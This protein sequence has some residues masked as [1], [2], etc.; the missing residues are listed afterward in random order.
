MA[1]YFM[2]GRPIIFLAKGKG[3]VAEAQ[4]MDKT[5]YHA[6]SWN[7]V[8]NLLNVLL[9][10]KDAMKEKRLAVIK[11]FLPNPTKSVSSAMLEYLKDD[12]Y[13]E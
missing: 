9:S 13:G 12:Y 4:H 10:G 7:E 11:E 1:E 3:F 6:F 2:T 5:L 8:E